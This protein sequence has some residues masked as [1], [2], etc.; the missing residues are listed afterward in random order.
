[1]TTR[2]VV[3]G[4]Y[5]AWT[6]RDFATARSFMADDLSFEG[7]IDRLHRADDLARE[8]GRFMQM[9]T[10]VRPIAEFFSADEAML[11]YDCVTPTPAGTIRTAEYFK[12]TDGKIR[13][14]KVVFDAGTLRQ[15]MAPPA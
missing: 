4:Y 14:I 11:L 1:M 5:K 9:V 10:E 8:L 2:D 6:S 15:M 7:P 12:T 13:E 3:T